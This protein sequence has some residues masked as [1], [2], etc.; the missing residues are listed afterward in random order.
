MLLS[1]ELFSSY[2]K[3]VEMPGIVYHYCSMSAFLSILE[4]STLRLSN[5]TKSNDS[6]EITNV[7]PTLRE[8][9]QMVLLDYNKRLSASYRFAPDTIAMLIDR[10][11]EELSKNFY[12]ICFSEERDLLSQWDR[13]ADHAQGVAIGFNTRHF[14]KLQIETEVQY[15]FGKIIYDKKVLSESAERFL[16]YQIDRAWKANDDLYN[17]NLIENVITN[18]VCTMLQYSVLFKNAFFAEENEWRLIYNPLG[19]IRRLGCAAAYH[20]RLLET[21]QYMHERCGFTRRNYQFKVINGNSI[22][23]Y[24]DLEFSALKDALIQEVIIG[25]RAL[26]STEDKDLLLFLAQHGYKV[27]TLTI[28]GNLVLSKSENPFQ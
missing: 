5:I 14:V 2:E 9:T 21:G 15:A 1:E 11:F 7:I 12:V 27:S 17:V 19:R 13:Y 18:L 22:S 6:S 28:E 23:S 26:L 24:V 16:R 8:I 10:F 25:P 4:T 3:A 20:D